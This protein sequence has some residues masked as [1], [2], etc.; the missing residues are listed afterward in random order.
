MNTERTNK[1]TV[2]DGLCGSGKTTFMLNWIVNQPQT[3]KIIWVTPF[4]DEITRVK[5]HVNT[6]RQFVEFQEPEKFMGKKFEGFKKLIDE[7]ANI[8]C[9]HSIF[10]ML[11]KDTIISIKLSGYI[12]IIDEALDVIEQRIIAK[13]DVATMI[14]KGIISVNGEGYVDWKGNEIGYPEDGDH[15]R[16]KEFILNNRVKL[17]DNSLVK[18]FPI[19]ALTVFRQIFI[20]TF[21][22]DGQWMKLWLDLYNIKY[23]LK[24]IELDTNGQYRIVNYQKP[25]VDAIKSLLNIYEGKM[26][27]IGKADSSGNDLFT[28]SRLNSIKSHNSKIEQVNRNLVNW[29]KNTVKAKQSEIIWTTTIESQRHFK[30]VYTRPKRF[31]VWNKRSTNDYRHT[32]K[33]AYLL[34]KHASPSL[35]QFFKSNGVIVDQRFLDMYSLSNIIQWVWRSQIRQGRPIDLYIPSERSRLLL[36]QYIN[37]QL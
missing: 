3:T 34:N 14:E 1:I 7:G 17:Y 36:N 8:V 18:V 23:E 11:D 19:E 5:N 24:S 13:H 35:V 15:S 29:F 10:G 32:K 22:W 37:G 20:L 21:L 2:I 16:H 26:N 6:N 4:L 25:N 27:D 30:T 31:V 33:L 28:Y 9:T 12:L